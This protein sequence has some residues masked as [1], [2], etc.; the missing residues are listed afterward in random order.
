MLIPTLSELSIVIAVAFA[1]EVIPSTPPDTVDV[2]TP[3]EESYEIPVPPLIAL[4]A[5]PSVY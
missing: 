1:L 2:I 5:F 4:L 3:V